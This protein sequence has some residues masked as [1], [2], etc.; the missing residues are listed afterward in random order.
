MSAVSLDFFDFNM[1]FSVFFSID[2][3]GVV[4]LVADVFA[5]TRLIF[6][7]FLRNVRVAPANSFAP[8]IRE[9]DFNSQAP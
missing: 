4:L 6:A 5:E 7:H 2:F 8:L 9:F 1:V 3:T